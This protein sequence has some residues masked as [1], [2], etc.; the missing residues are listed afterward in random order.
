MQEIVETLHVPVRY[1]CDVC[2][3]GGGI[4][5]IAAALAARRG[6]ADV[7]LLEREY[8]LGGLATA[9][10]ITIFLPI[11][12]GKGHQ[13]SFGLAEELLRLS[14]KHGAEYHYPAHWM[15]P[16]DVKTRAEN[17]RF[18]VHYNPYL[19]A[20][21]AER[22]LI[23]EGVK[24]LYGVTVAAAHVEHGKIR[25]IVL[26]GKSGR[27]AVEIRRSAVDC[28]GDADLCLAAGEET[29][30]YESG[31][32]LA[33]WYYGAGKDGYTKVMARKKK[34]SDKPT[35]GGE[36]ADGKMTV[37]ASVEGLTDFT[38][39]SHERLLENFMEHRRD[40]PGFVP[41][42]ITIVPQV[43]MTRRIIGVTDCDLS[44]DH[45]RIKDSVGAFSNWRVRGPVYELPYSSLFGKRVRNLAAAGRCLSAT[46]AMWDFSRVIPACA[47]S[48]EAAGCAAGMTDDL[49]VLKVADLQDELTKRGVHIHP[50]W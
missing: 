32:G 14:I 23:S 31:N 36:L 2:V 40:D 8:L 9:G 37:G 44:F 17:E 16:F 47:V 49:S 34:V 29:A 48:G 42:S 3:C 26:E 5:G 13:V 35:H 27:E 33:C 10:M 24:I 6:G 12:D 15:E 20:I 4:A 28:T 21:E 18:E 39:R 25:E 38:I 19:F 45:K 1:S 7:L 46:D 30:V 50:E 41:A 43:L 11:C 22:L